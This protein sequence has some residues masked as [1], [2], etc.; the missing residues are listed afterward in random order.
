[1]TMQKLGYGVWIERTYR[2]FKMDL[3]YYYPLRGG[4]P[5]NVA[6]SVFMHL[7]ERRE[8]LPFEDIKLYV[9]SKYAK[10]VQRHF[11][12]F[13]VI[14]YKDINSISRNSV[15]HIPVSPLIYPNSKFLL[16]LSAILRRR[17]LILNYHGDIRKEMQL[18][19]KYEHSL[20]VSNIPSYIAMPYLLKSADK[21]IVNSYLMSNLVKT[22]YGVKNCVVI[23][24]G[25]DNFWFEE[26]NETNVE[27][28]GSPIFFYHG[29]L[30]PEKGVDLLIKGF[31]EAI[32]KHSNAKLYIA[33]DGSQREYLKNLCMKLGIERN[34]A[35]L[36]FLNKEKIK[37]YLKSVDAAIYPSIWDNFPLSFLEA[38]SSA[39]CPV[40]FSKEAGIHDFV[41]RDGYRLKAFDPTVDDISNIIKDVIDG[42]SNNQIV[43]Q[44]KEFARRYTWN[45]VINQYIE[46]YNQICPI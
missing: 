10:K 32:R 11:D 9:A 1:M 27:L 28:E 4:A 15:I 42:S 20:N 12:D 30:S 26:N 36:G 16:H 43:K 39:N 2:E 6:R 3:I 31:A 18:N 25:I 21:L 23:P 38:F 8:E 44:Q 17:K 35:F 37:A 13:E 29:R 34:V 24:N 7:Q 46:L 19:L 22:K 41:I 5:A 45:K 14:T 40:Y 33:A